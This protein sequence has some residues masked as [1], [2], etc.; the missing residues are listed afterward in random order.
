MLF[1][2]ICAIN[3][4]GKKESF[5]NDCILKVKNCDEKTGGI[6]YFNNFFKNNLLINIYLKTSDFWRLE[7]V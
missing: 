7:N 5:D 1:A 2:P 3:S 6:D 4:D